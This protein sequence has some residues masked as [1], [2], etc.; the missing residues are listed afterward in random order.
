MFSDFFD[1]T[2]AELEMQRSPQIKRVRKTK[3]ASTKTVQPLHAH[4]SDDSEG[5]EVASGTFHI[6]QISFNSKTST[7][8]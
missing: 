1:T 3:K 4:D 8:N 2:E 7:F 6:F 5:E